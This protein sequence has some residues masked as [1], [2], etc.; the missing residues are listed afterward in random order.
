MIGDSHAA[1]FGQ[2]GFRPG[3]VKA[4]YGTGSSLMSRTPTLVFSDHGL[5]STVAWAIGRDVAYALEGNISATGAAL[6]WVADLLGLADP[7]AAADLAASVSSAEGTSFVPAF[8][9]LGAPYWAERARGLVS[10]ITRST[11][12]AHLARA[13]LE[14]IAF[15]VRDVFVA[16]M[17]DVRTDGA[18][19]LADG[20][21]SRS[22]FLMQFQA[23]VIGEPVVRN[24]AADIS[25]LGAAYLAGLALGHW[26]SVDEIESLPRTLERFEPRIDDA[27]RET[28]LAEWQGAVARC[29]FEPD[30]PRASH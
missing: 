2:G 16:M 26:R 14:S 25:A 20:G 9:G 29:L 21:A 4:T 3:S 10:G 27:S 30:A 12:A 24:N 19:L 17:C 23:D 6:Q 18:V 11:S 1:L 22:D 7:A 28:A 13:A 15:Q 8:V 5:S